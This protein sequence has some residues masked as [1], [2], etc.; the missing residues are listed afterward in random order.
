MSKTCSIGIDV[1]GTKT[2]LALFDDAFGVIENIKFK[3]PQ[4][5]EE[6]IAA[7]TKSLKKFVR[8]ADERS[9][10]ISGLGVGVAGSVDPKGVVHSAPNIGFL[11]GFSF[12]KAAVDLCRCDVSV[13]NDVHAAL[14][15]ELKLG[16]AVGYKHVIG[17]FIG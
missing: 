11:D 14:Y 7:F 12:K 2:R 6:F 10:M 4:T 3:T 17:V 9:L 15:G 1:G 8:I 5:K 13:H 16:V